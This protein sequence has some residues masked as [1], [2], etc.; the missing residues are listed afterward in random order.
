MVGPEALK[1]ESLP[2]CGQGDV[3][4]EDTQHCQ[5]KDRVRGPWQVLC[6]ARSEVGEKTS[7]QLSPSL[8]EETQLLTP[9]FTPVRL[10]VDL[11]TVWLKSLKTLSL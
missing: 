1:A 8:Q 11:E 10:A 5:P 9:D 2:D 7:D 6:P 4:M 3:G